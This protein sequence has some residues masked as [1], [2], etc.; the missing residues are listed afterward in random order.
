MHARLAVATIAVACGPYV[1]H[2]DFRFGDVT[3]R[4][5]L[6]RL[7][8]VQYIASRVIARCQV[9]ERQL[10][11]VA[12]AHAL[13]MCATRGARPHV[14]YNATSAKRRPFACAFTAQVA[15]RA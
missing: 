5:V 6:T 4:C 2:P 14:T 11:R 7:A 12:K 9:S 3:P 15:S 13:D 1:V 10:V 8:S